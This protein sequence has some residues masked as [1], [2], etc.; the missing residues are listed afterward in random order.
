[1][2]RVKPSLTVTK[3]VSPSGTAVPGT[4]LTYTTT[5][6]NV[7]SEKASALVHVDS[8]PPQLGFKVGSVSTALPSG[9]TATIAYSNDGGTT[10][11]YV[12]VSAGCGAPAGY[13][14]CVQDIR[15]LLSGALNGNGPNNT[16]QIVFVAK[17]K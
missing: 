17:V 5:L 4:D 14:Y 2:V 7:G 10:W 16:V 11:T 12:P 1:V 9:M 3:S 13:D 8:V 15:T 6:T